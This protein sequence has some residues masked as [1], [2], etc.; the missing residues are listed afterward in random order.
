MCVR[1][2]NLRSSNSSGFT[3]VYWDKIIK[4]W[5]ISIILNNKSYQREGFSTIEDAINARKTKAKEHGIQ[6]VDIPD[7]QKRCSK[8][9]V[10]K[11]LEEFGLKASSKDGRG[12]Y[13]FECNSEYFKELSKNPER[14][15][16]MRLAG[17]KHRE[18]NREF[19]RSHKRKR[20]S[21]LYRSDPAWHL[22]LKIRRRIHMA[23]R[24]GF[25][26]KRSKVKTIDLLGCNY[27]FLKI[28]IERKFSAGMTWEMVFN[29]E[30][31]LDHIRPCISF[32]L[33]DPE[34]QKE[35]FNYKNLQPLWAADNL[36]KAIYTL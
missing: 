1:T 26:G 35:C 12:S 10:V 33:T 30:I 28:F 17:K 25:N 34:Q 18:N 11:T 19:I 29:G 31:H 36:S 13:C 20:Y 4:K 9:G 27:E 23:L 3:G 24:G 2:Y 32:D 8:C 6:C 22:D 16:Q 7:G 14:K 15:A 21:E 5:K